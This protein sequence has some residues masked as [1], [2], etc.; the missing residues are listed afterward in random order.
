MPSEV[1]QIFF[2]ILEK[3]TVITIFITA[4]KRSVVDSQ[5]SPLASIYLW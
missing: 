1:H 2:N 4:I 5:I 3:K